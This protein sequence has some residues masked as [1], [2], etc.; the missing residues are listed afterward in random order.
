MRAT[1]I[2]DAGATAGLGHLSRTGAVAVALRSRGVDVRC[3]AWGADD[4][5]ERDGLR[6]EALARADSPP[7]QGVVV[8]DSYEVSA[9]SVRGLAADSRLVL[10]HGRD[11]VPEAEIVTSTVAREDAPGRL[12]LFGL[13]Y[14]CLRPSYWGVPERQ[15]PDSVRRVLVATGGGDAGGAAAG[16]AEAAQ[17][18]LPDAEVAVLRGPY[19]SGEL[20]GG[21]V[22]VEDPAS[23]FDELVAADLI[24][25]AAGQTLLEA[26]AAGTPAIA[27]V[28]A[29]NQRSQAEAVASADAAV[30]AEPGAGVSAAVGELA[31]DE[32]RRAALA[33]HGQ[34]L[35]DG[36]GAL[37]VGFHVG[38]LIEAASDR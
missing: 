27:V 6:W 22:A 34:Q 8:L 26:A 25:T 2:A 9:D 15:T 38:R 14:A 5:I 10:M 23:P 1:L 13:T 24:V 18:A 37:R 20:P 32:T 28:T 31:A 19:A 4:P 36:F 12:R 29:E 3:L 17:D 11:A 21:V 33:K 7:A 16:L 30:I 35:I